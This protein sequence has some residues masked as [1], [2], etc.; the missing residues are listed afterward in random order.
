M[1]KDKQSLSTAI[2]LFLVVIVF[3]FPFPNSN[4]YG[5][6]LTSVF[7]IPVKSVNGIQYVGL[8]SLIL[9]LISFYFLAR[10]LSKYHVRFILLAIVIMNLFPPF[11]IQ[12]YQKTIATGIYAISYEQRLSKCDFEMSNNNTL[13]GVCKLPFENYSR[14]DVEFTVEF[15]NQSSNINSMVSL[16]NNHA[17]YEVKLNGKE[18]KQIII[19]TMIEV[20]DNQNMRGQSGFIDIIIKS[21]DRSRKL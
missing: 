3:N 7:N 18:R 1:I 8:A 13:Y 16:M 2:I 15:V 4:P 5:E 17:P 14:D 19:E 20:S 12:A 6:T 9:L 10:S 21:G 11:L